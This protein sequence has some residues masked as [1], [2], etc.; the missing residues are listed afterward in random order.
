MMLGMARFIPRADGLM[1]AG[2]WEKKSLQG[3]ELRGKTLGVIGL[4]KIGME[5]ARRA[6]AFGMEI[7]GHDPFVSASIAK[8]NGI[9]MGKLEDVYAA[10]DYLTLHVGLTPQTTGMINAE[11]IKTMKKGVRIVN[12]ARGELIDEAAL[13]QGLKQGQVGGAAL[14]VFQEEPL[15]NSPLT[16]PWRTSS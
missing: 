6:R 3:T 8:E 15:K 10:A 13:A 5:V 14:D 12:C 4:G 7:V 2:K 16:S 1:H 11:S 9:R